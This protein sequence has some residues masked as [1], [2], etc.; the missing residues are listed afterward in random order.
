MYYK[1][2]N[3]SVAI[4]G[5]TILEEVNF[6]IKDR[7][8]IAIVGRN[9]SGK[10]TLLKALIDGEMFGEGVGE[11]KF[12]I[13]WNG[14]PIIGYLKQEGLREDRTLI[15]EILEVYEPIRELEEKIKSLEEELEKGNSDISEKYL[16]LRERY[17]LQ[18][19]YEYKKEYTLGLRKFG[20][21]EE[22]KNRLIG[23][24]SGGERTKIALLKLVL[25][26]PD[27]LLL[28]EAT[29]HLDIEATEWLEDYLK[30]Y[31]KAIV[32]VSHD[33]MFINKIVNKIYEIEYGSLEEYVGNYDYY[34]EEKKRRYAKTLKDYERQQKEIKRLQGIA[35]RFRY[36]PA[37]ASMALAKLKQIERMVM[38]E[39]P[40]KENKKTF[41][42]GSIDFKE[43]Y[44]DVLR[45]EELEIGYDRVLSKVTFSLE[46]GERLGIIGSNGRGKST[47]LKTLVGM[48]QALGGDYQIGKNVKIGYFDQQLATLDKSKTIY[49]EFS[50]EFPMFNDFQ[51]RSALASFMFYQYEIDKKIEVLS[52]GEKVRLELCK[53]IYN[54]PNLLI[55]DE[56][57]NHLDILSKM[58]LESV[59]KEYS[60]TIIFVSH[61]RYFVKEIASSL[62]VFDDKSTSYFNYTYLEYLDYIKKQDKLL[63]EDKSVKEKREEKKKNF[64][65]SEKILKRLE[66][67][68]SKLE[69]EIKELEESLFLEEV[70]SDYMKIE[71]VKTLIEGKEE[72]LEK[73]ME[74]WEMVQSA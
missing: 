55:L 20:F 61:D 33:R 32:L 60:G 56:P 38:I 35:D 52:G 23:S 59:L 15:E 25:S 29:N 40:D 13:V 1:V 8:R 47:L 18:G 69:S 16:D 54:G 63:E 11:E 71:K 31:P 12:G 48:I 30:S 4:G 53:I 50:Q 39:K 9:G 19:G 37:K 26:K 27:I 68:I 57:T 62:L 49:E 73:L 70:Y 46:R 58:M 17:Q 36:K 41:N 72:E 67:D 44:R 2:T 45:V 65:E 64:R 22:D 28:D 74:E 42:I 5:K 6:E 66:R 7:D 43:S 51:V 3:G 34:V 14:K 24:F 10:T 21:N